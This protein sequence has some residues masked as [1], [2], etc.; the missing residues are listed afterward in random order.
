[1]HRRSQA[2]CVSPPPRL[3]AQFFSPP[4]FYVSPP[5]FFPL[6]PFSVSPPFL[7][8]FDSNWNE[9]NGG[10]WPSFVHGAAKDVG[11]YYQESTGADH[12]RCPDGRLNAWEA[13]VPNGVYTVT[14]GLHSLYSQSSLHGCTFE[15]V[16]ADGQ[17]GNTYVF[18]VEVAD[19]KFTLSSG[20]PS[21]C[22]AVSWLKLDM[23]SS[24]VFPKPWLP[25]PPKAWWQ[26]ELDD[27]TADVGMVEVRLPHEGFSTANTYPHAAEYGVADCRQWWLYAPAKCYRMFTYS[28]MNGIHPEMVSYPNFPGFTEPFL[29]WY[30]DQHDT[31]ADGE[32]VYQEF[33]AAQSQQFLTGNYSMWRRP[34]PHNTKGTVGYHDDNAAHLWVKLNVI[35]Q[36]GGSSTGVITKDE[37]VHGML[38]Q[39]RTLFCDLFESTRS[40][41]GG[42][43]GTGWCAR[44]ISG[45]RLP[46]Q[47]GHFNDDGAH[48]FVVSVS[49]TA[50]TD[51]DGCP[52]V[53][54]GGSSNTTLCEFR[55]HRSSGGAAKVNCNGAKGKYL[56]IALPGDSQR[57]VPT[58]F[59]TAHRASVALLPGTNASTATASTNPKLQTVCYG[60]KPRA[61]P[62]ADAPDLLAA[63]K[64]HPKTIVDNNPEDPIWWSTC[65]DRVVIKDWLPLN[66]A[67]DGDGESYDQ[68]GVPYEYKNGTYCLACESVRQNY[69]ATI[70]RQRFTDFNARE[71]VYDFIV[72]KRAHSGLAGEPSGLR[73]ADITVDGVRVNA[74][75]IRVRKN[76][77]FAFGT[78][79]VVELGGKNDDSLMWDNDTTTAAGWETDGPT[80]TVLSGGNVDGA[81]NLAACTGECDDDDQC[82]TGLKCFNREEG[83]EIP[84]CMGDGGGKSWDYCHDPKS[85]N[86][87]ADDHIFT[88][89]TSE[90]VATFGITYTDPKYAPGWKIT[91]NGAEFLVETANRGPAATGSSTF[92]YEFEVKIGGRHYD[93]EAMST[94][95][96]WLQEEGA[97]KNCDAVV[98]DIHT[99]TTTST[100]TS[101]STSTSTSTTTSTSTST[102]AT[103]STATSSTATSILATKAVSN[104]T[105][106]GCAG[107]YCGESEAEVQA[108]T[109]TA[110]RAALTAAGVEASTVATILAEMRSI[111]DGSALATAAATSGLAAAL[112]TEKF[113]SILADAGLDD[114]A[115][116]AV[117]AAATAA[118]VEAADSNGGGDAAV[119]AKTNG[120]AVAGGIIAGLGV[121][122]LLIGGVMMHNARN[123]NGAGDGAGPSFQNPVYDQG[124]DQGLVLTNS[125]RV[126][127]NPIESIAIPR[128][129]ISNDPGSRRASVNP[130]A[131]MAIPRA[132]NSNDPG[133]F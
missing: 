131:S 126:S 84:G 34:A 32:L 117:A 80:L 9:K 73:I 72:V 3:S 92:A 19:G 119:P 8:W 2:Y 108:A 104:A 69:G 62:A 78:R 121:V 14:A 88:I 56:Q 106:K 83:E 89:T 49:D 43:H 59:V 90:P 18:S 109:E 55:T 130:I 50:C 77:S 64:I 6:C 66:G 93:K 5:F 4:F 60:V 67:E 21:K 76:S 101:S 27:A 22:Q 57:L 102:T 31:N 37:W 28:R 127:V 13:T 98:F 7:G 12:A 129:S 26:L 47:L 113:A 122:G 36:A 97:C 75:Q 85:A 42:N 46:E 41:H 17:T 40:T 30:F 95:R 44:D 58:L 23:I 61:P 39:P 82:A 112:A 16:K 103:S 111:M 10:V 29:T 125:R 132:G 15:N 52:A 116:A 25:A 99:S 94:R 24:K 35:H 96:W 115:V 48:G 107:L 20:P 123:G 110:L 128:A 63:A 86:A 91:E 45:P 53:E 11:N 79:A 71:Y 114:S 54:P 100:S 1:M 87:D 51:Q 33:R 118:E 74:T 81:T 70:T 133:W 68:N 124:L 38:S 105:T 65:Y 120:G